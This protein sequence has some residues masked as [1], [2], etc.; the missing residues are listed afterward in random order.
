M[1]NSNRQS[2]RATPLG[3]DDQ[4]ERQLPPEVRAEL[5]T[6]LSALNRWPRR[7]PETEEEIQAALTWFKAKGFLREPN[8]P[9]PRKAPPISQTPNPPRT[10]RSRRFGGLI[11]IVLGEALLWALLHYQSSADRNA[12]DTT[13][14]S[15]TASLPARAPSGLPAYTGSRP[16]DVRR[17]LPIDVRRAMPVVPRAEPL[18]AST[19]VATALSPE[20]GVGDW[21]SVTLLDGTTTVSAC[22]E[23]WL[24]SSANLP[25]QGHFIGEELAVGSGPHPTTWIWMQPAGGVASWVDP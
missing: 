22:F 18:N 14:A 11:W 12:G 4:F 13:S 25:A 7:P 24:P 6:T 8:P 21:H 15:G 19:R 2:L 5:E 9:A 20:I 1:A 17:A 3:Y 16:V 23:G 10:K